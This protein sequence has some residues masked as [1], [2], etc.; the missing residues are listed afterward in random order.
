VVPESFLMPVM[1]VRFWLG[2]ISRPAE[3][4]I[5]LEYD[6]LELIPADQ[7]AEDCFLQWF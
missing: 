1:A 6:L 2:I 4:I 5:N 7:I 3:G